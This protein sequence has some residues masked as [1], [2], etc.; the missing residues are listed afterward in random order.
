MAPLQHGY[1]PEKLPPCYE[2]GAGKRFAR[3]VHIDRLEKI[4]VFIFL[5]SHRDREES[6]NPKVCISHFVYEDTSRTAE[7]RDSMRAARDDPRK[8]WM[9]FDTVSKAHEGRSCARAAIIH[10][11]VLHSVRFPEPRLS[12][13]P[14]PALVVAKDEVVP[15]EIVHNTL[16]PSIAL[17]VVHA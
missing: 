3:F 13:F 7:R 4:R 9:P 15:L 11:A 2:R 6:E 10:P 14:V 16:G 1:I 8:E 17:D 5:T 12:T